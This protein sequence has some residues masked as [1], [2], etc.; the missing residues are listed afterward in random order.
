MRRRAA[1]PACLAVAA[2]T[3]AVGACE[4]GRSAANHV[5]VPGGHPERGVQVM[6]DFGCGSCHLI[7]GVDGASGTVGPP[8][9]QWARRSY[10]AG[11][12][13][14]APDNLIRWVMAPHSV[15]PG[16]AMPDLPL[17]EQQAR[18]VAAYLYTLR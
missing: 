4:G 13:P 1:Q 5:V 12:L 11:N 2:L 9:T 18:D 14:N 6:E 15:E 3:L 17:T 10:I 8:L 7:P 16:T